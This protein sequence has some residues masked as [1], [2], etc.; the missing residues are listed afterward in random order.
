MLKRTLTLGTLLVLAIVASAQMLIQPNMAGERREIKPAVPFFIPHW[1]VKAQGGVAYDVG[2]AKFSQL[3]S[4]SI[5][6][7]LGY[8]FNEYFGLRGSLSG[9]WA[10]NRYSYPEKKYSWNFF[11]PALDAEFD[12]T[13]LI[14]GKN[15][16]RMTNV[17][18]FAGF[19]VA[20]SFNNDDVSDARNEFLKNYKFYNN[21]LVQMHPNYF[22]KAWSSSRWNPVVRFGLGA[23][24]Q[25]SDQISIGAEVNANMLPDHFNSKKG[26]SDNKDWHFNALVGIKFTIGK[27]HGKLDP[28]YEEPAPVTRAVAS[29]FVDVPIEKIS[30]NV[31]IYFLINQSI[32]R[33]NQIPKLTALLKYLDDHPRAFIR[34]SGFAD[35][36]TGTPEINMRLSIERSQVVSKYLQDKGIEEW[37]IRRF[38]KGDKVQPFD[39]PEDNRVCICYVYD[40]DNPVPQEFT[41]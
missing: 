1:Y 34:L 25:I 20:Y 22:E 15:P 19:G 32:I 4:P 9:L 36:E 27:S 23:D 33:S 17:Y 8:K 5:Q 41:Y 38:A 14:L 6:F 39:I 30:F 21:P 35:K 10:Q 3:L 12:L 13:N 2:E 31:N 7:A 37:R 18:A 26:K 29:K 28:V 24:Y 40:P 16:E 11:Q